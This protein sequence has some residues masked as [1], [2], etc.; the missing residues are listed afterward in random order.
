MRYSAFTE[1]QCNAGWFTLLTSLL[2]FFRVKR[3]ERGILTPQQPAV[4]RTPEEIA[5]EHALL[6][7]M[8]SSFGL[9]FPSR[10]DIRI[11]L[12]LGRRRD[13]EGEFVVHESAAA[14]RAD[15]HAEEEDAGAA[16]ARRREAAR[17]T[18]RRL[19]DGLQA[20]GLL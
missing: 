5:R 17:E 3:W 9:S 19:R 16:L 18:D 15:G 12:G 8:E 4:P 10:Q 1:S 6:S 20:A 11:G 2:G 14:G 13:S 7:N